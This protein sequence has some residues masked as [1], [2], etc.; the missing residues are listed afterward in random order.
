MDD[1]GNKEILGFSSTKSG[2]YTQLMTA[3]RV[4]DAMIFKKSGLMEL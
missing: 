4:I 3:K 1:Y 2:I